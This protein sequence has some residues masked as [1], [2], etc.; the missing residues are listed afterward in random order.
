MAVVNHYL[1]IGNTGLEYTLDDVRPEHAIAF[2]SDSDWHWSGQAQRKTEVLA[3]QLA[4]RFA[5]N[6]RYLQVYL[7]SKF[8]YE[9]IGHY[10]DKHGYD[11]TVNVVYGVIVS[12]HSAD[13][14]GSAAL[15]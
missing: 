4:S 13:E 7:D 6:P 11:K 14:Q 9:Q 5:V 8:T 12:G 2:L 3:K 1:R 15:A 10:V